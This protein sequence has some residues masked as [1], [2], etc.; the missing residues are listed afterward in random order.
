MFSFLFI[1][2]LNSVNFLEKKTEF[3][4]IFIAISLP[5]EE[6]KFVQIV[7]IS[8]TVHINSFRLFIGTVQ[9]DF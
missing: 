7:L 3:N 6:F 8:I 5:Q 9:R 4:K 2:F 1:R